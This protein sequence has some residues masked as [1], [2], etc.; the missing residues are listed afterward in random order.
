MSIQPVPEPR[1]TT[2]LVR[3]WCAWAAAVLFVL[4]LSAW[5]FTRDRLPA[6]IRISTGARGGQYYQVGEVLAEFMGKRTG[7][8]V[9]VLESAG[10]GENLS[11]VAEAQADL[12]IVQADSF[13]LE[14]VAV[15][16]PLYR[17][18]MFVIVRK[19]SGLRGIRDLAG[20]KVALG[21]EGSGMKNS[22]KAILEH[23]G[24]PLDSLKETGRYFTDLLKDSSLDA[25][26]V[27][28]GFENPDLREVLRSGTFELLPVEDAEALSVRYPYLSP[29]EIP[30][31]LFAEGPPV[32]AQS[33]ATVAAMAVLV[34]HPRAGKALINATL[35]ALYETPA[36][37]RIKQL[38]PAKQAADWPRLTLHPAAHSYFDPYEGVGLLSDFMQSIAA[39]KELLFA[40]GAGL[41]L[42]WDRWQ[43]LKEKERQRQLSAQKERLDVYLTETLQ[44]EKAQMSA[45]DPAQMQAY[46]HQVTEIKLKALEE[47]TNEDLRGDQV[48]AIFLS[49]CANLILKLQSKILLAKQDAILRQIHPLEPVAEP[50]P[51]NKP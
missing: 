15:L 16:A 48:F 42:A 21:R 13:P 19:N 24:V 31:G 17:E 30:R 8:T 33:V 34:A 47:L 40:F 4:S 45:E 35:E 11:R 10:S 27:T 20:R 25:A 5:Y 46:L 39:F 22:A 14:G 1:T 49:Q 2:G 26:L 37:D 38:I 7:R 51:E 3:R 23:Y 6:E 43:K 29:V 12:A 50:K 32:P 44:I 9:A 18:P 28:T 41:Y 36:A